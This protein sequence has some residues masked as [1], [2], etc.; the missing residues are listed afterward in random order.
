MP[1]KGKPLIKL[2]LW[3]LL[4]ISVGPVQSYL[5]SFWLNNPLTL[6]PDERRARKFRNRKRANFL[7]LSGVWWLLQEKPA[8][9][10]VCFTPVLPPI[11]ASDVRIHPIRKSFPMPVSCSPSLL[12]KWRPQKIQESHVQQQLLFLTF[13]QTILPLTS[14]LGLAHF[15]LHSLQLFKYLRSSTPDPSFSASTSGYL[16]FDNLFT[17]TSVS[18]ALV[19]FC[20]LPVLCNLGLQMKLAPVCNIEMQYSTLQP[21]RWAWGADAA[22]A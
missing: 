14:L 17:F 9:L 16:F 3:S 20:T 5:P 15:L 2:I 13:A 10:N 12:T 19:C 8:L 1:I 6:F 4:S 7:F 22:F 18:F 11:V 21:S